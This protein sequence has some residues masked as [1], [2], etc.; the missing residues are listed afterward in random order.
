MEQPTSSE[1]VFNRKTAMALG[2]RIPQSLLLRAD[3]VVE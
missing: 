2:V 3:R 1:L